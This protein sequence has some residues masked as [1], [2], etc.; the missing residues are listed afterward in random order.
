[1]IVLQAAMD[2]PVLALLAGFLRMHEPRLVESHTEESLILEIGRARRHA[3]LYGISDPIAIS[4]FFVARAHHGADFDRH[5]EVQAIL[6]DVAIPA[7]TRIHVMWARIP[8][9]MWAELD[10]RRSGK[11]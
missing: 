6:R 1:M 2:R 5:P 4:E 3:A 8:K 7:D 9:T 11:V 10:A